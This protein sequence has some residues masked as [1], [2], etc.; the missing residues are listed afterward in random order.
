[1]DKAEKMYVQLFFKTSASSSLTK[2]VTQAQYY[3]T[4]MS[5]QKTSSILKVPVD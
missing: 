5:I 1:M 2:H 3:C 4:V